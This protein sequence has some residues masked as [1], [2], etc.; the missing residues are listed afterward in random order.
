MNSPMSSS[1]RLLTTLAGGIPD[2][3]PYFLPVTMHGG[4]GSRRRPDEYFRSG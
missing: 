2:R 3:V 1:E 4:D